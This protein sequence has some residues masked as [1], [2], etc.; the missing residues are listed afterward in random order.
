M[1]EM[2][3]LHYSEKRRKPFGSEIRLVSAPLPAPYQPCPNDVFYVVRYSSLSHPWFPSFAPRSRVRGGS[4]GSDQSMLVFVPVCMVNLAGACFA[5]AVRFS[6]PLPCEVENLVVC[7]QRTAKVR[8]FMGPHTNCGVGYSKV[9][10]YSGWG[11]GCVRNIH[12]VDHNVLIV[13]L[14]PEDLTCV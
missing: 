7:S 5:L 2:I 11:R 12:G 14:H 10:V 13:W 1:N 4:S 8:V 6:G 9:L 3:V